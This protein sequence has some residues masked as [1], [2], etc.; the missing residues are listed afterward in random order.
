MFLGEYRREFDLPFQCLVHPR[1][2]DDD[3][4]RWLKEA[5]CEHVQMGVQ[6]VDEEYK[7]HQLLRMESDAHT[8][9]ALAS[10]AKF[11]LDLK[12]VHLPGVELTTNSVGTEA[13]A[14]HGGVH[15]H[16]ARCTPAASGS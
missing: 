3:I 11:N 15:R 4:A 1:F 12:L 5:G 13:P 14:G 16:D 8:R 7:R 10:L 9:N 6:S 2:V